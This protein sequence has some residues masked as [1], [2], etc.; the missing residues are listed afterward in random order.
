MTAAS[1]STH[2]AANRSGL[3]TFLRLLG[4]WATVAVLAYL[5]W[6]PA[7]DFGWLKMVFVWVLLTLLADEFAGWFGYIGLGLGVLP[8][9]TPNLQT[10]EQWFVVFPL[11]A[12]AI[13]AYLL[14]KHSGGPFVL[15]FAAALFAGAILAAAKFGIKLDPSL[16]LPAS[17]SFQETALAPM[18]AVTAFSFVRQLTSMILRGNRA[19]KARAAARASA[20]AMTPDVTVVTDAT[21]APASAETVW[22]TPVPPAPHPTAASAET[23]TI[24]AVVPPVT[25]DPASGSPGSRTNTNVKDFVAATP[26][27]TA[28]TKTEKQRN[29]LTIDLDL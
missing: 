10:P 8:F 23:T 11:L 20:A 9:L 24:S 3:W 27:S 7:Q 12:G 26:E 19:R 22:P 17:R 2:K 5:L 15:P 1:A 25:T 4:G 6:M 21:A 16:T 18:L 14:M 29:P 28:A 13:G